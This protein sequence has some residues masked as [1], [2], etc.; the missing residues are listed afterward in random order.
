MLT[1]PSLIGSARE[2]GCGC[3]STATGKGRQAVCE[4][5]LFGMAQGRATCR[6]VV[7]REKHGA[8]P[9]GEDSAKQGVEMEATRTMALKFKVK[10]KDEIPAELVNL[11]V[12][13]DG[14][15]LLDVEGAVCVRA[16][17]PTSLLGHETLSAW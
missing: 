17:F 10:L 6:R 11:Y 3:Q 15:W 12:E 5:L 2:D 9:V 13:R 7:Q 14:A 4:K 1:L 8:V 16:R